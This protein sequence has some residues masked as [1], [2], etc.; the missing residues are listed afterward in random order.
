MFQTNINLRKHFDAIYQNAHIN[1]PMRKYN[2]LQ[3]TLKM[4][5]IRKYSFAIML[6]QLGV[7]FL[8]LYF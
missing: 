4:V 8:K 6:P 1:F 5:H 7:N 2:L 3:D